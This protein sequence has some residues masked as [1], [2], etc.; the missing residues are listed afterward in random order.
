MVNAGLRSEELSNLFEL[1][2]ADND[3]TITPEELINGIIK[4]DESHKDQHYKEV[5]AAKV[6]FDSSRDARGY[7]PGTKL[8]L[9]NTGGAKSC[10]SR[11]VS[12]SFSSLV[13]TSWQMQSSVLSEGSVHTWLGCFFPQT[14]PVGAYI[15]ETGFSG[16]V[17]PGVFD[18]C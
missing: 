3:G 5:K 7:Y 2:D 8:C 4:I 12:V 1:L 15:V 10:W 11:R 9:L 18:T 16:V 6:G 13:F 14:T 17:R